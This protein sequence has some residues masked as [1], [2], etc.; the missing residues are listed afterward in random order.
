MLHAL[1]MF[2]TSTVL[3]TVVAEIGGVTYYAWAATFFA[4]GSIVG[5]VT[6]LPFI[7]KL[8]P[9]HAYLFGVLLFAVGGSIC[10]T[11]PNMAMFTAGRALQGLGG[12]LMS[13]MA[14]AMVPVV[15]PDAL[16]PGAVALISSVWGPAAL[17][18]PL[19]GGALA[20]G[21]FWRTA[22]WTAAPIGL[23]LAI[24]AYS[25]LPTQSLLSDR[26]DGFSKALGLRLILVAMAALSLTVSSIPGRLSVSS[27]GVGGALTCL[28]IAIRLDE[29]DTHRI[30]LRGG[31]DI[32]T[33]TGSITYTMILLVL[34]VGTTSFI[35]YVFRVGFGAP[36][37]VGGYV[38]ALSSLA[39][40]LG[41][42]STAGVGGAAR[43]RLIA[44]APLVCV[45]GLLGVAQGLSKS[46]LPLTAVCWAMFGGG[47][48]ISWPHLASSL[49]EC[50]PASEREAAG[51]F[52]TLLQIGG[53]ALGA[54]F[55]GMVANM[56]GLP[57][58]SSRAGV[59]VAAFGLFT[60]FAVAP[61][62]AAFFANR[63]LRDDNL[64]RNDPA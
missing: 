19:F 61:L 53:A 64:Y 43:R 21:G 4:V 50:S 28:C 36:P 59:T 17:A 35:P 48:G 37:L 9:R 45:A 57:M 63:F 62:L 41:T 8:G 58:A 7:A 3:P 33:P 12:G 24:L 1:F 46:D 22:F 23:F 20:G 55:A 13:G 27:I 2:I 11:A 14:F 38:A 51:A 29:R 34:G 6:T 18:G 5:A 42:L 56:T 26:G 25:V 44:L 31:F 49:I 10:A 16:R 40:T 32:A 15:F 60:T 39:W 52:V 47:V 54:A 30:F